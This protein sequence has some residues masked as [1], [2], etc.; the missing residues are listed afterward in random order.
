VLLA[1]VEAGWMVA[2]GT[3]AL[4]T[5]D[6]VEVAGQLQ[7]AR[8]LST[9]NVAISSRNSGMYFWYLLAIDQPFRRGLYVV[10]GPELEIR[11][12]FSCSK[13]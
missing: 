8:R 4:V 12:D 7:F 6:Y 3:R 1:G 11:Q 2:D 9:T 10:S 5:E 13:L